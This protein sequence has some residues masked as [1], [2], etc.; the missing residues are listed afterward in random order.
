MYICYNLKGGKIIMEEPAYITAHKYSANHKKVLEKDSVCG[1]FYCLEIFSPQEIYE[2]IP[3]ISGTAVCP[4]CGID[5][6]I[7]ESSGYPITK[8]FLQEMYD[9]WFT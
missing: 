7:G 2:W 9:Y 5:S 8:E 3:D 4:Y 1:C 6:V